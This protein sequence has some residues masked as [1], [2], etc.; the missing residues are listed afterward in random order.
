MEKPQHEPGE[1]NLEDLAQ[2]YGELMGKLHGLQALFLA[3]H[4][5]DNLLGSQEEDMF[6]RFETDQIE[7]IL[8]ELKDKM[9]IPWKPHPEA[10]GEGSSDTDASA[11]TYVNPVSKS[12][13][14]YEVTAAR[15]TE[16]IE[17][18]MTY[19][20]NDNGRLE[21]L[22]TTETEEVPNTLL[23][24]EHP[25]FQSIELPS[26]EKINL[27]NPQEEPIKVE[28]SPKQA[29]EFV[30]MIKEIVTRL[31][32]IYNQSGWQVLLD[33]DRT[34]NDVESGDYRAVYK[35]ERIDLD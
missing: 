16:Q 18:I 31:G 17:I 30:A 9:P 7:L 1:P 28:M 22:I 15:G 14:R 5:A 32:K 6:Q 19:R 23:D 21:Q 3:R 12:V 2:Q 27:S 35:I 34:P 20:I 25:A 4:N 29:K 24:V 33:T 8:D 13:V 10:I 26:G 11:D